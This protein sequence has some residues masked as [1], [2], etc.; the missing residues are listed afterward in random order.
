MFFTHVGRI[1]AILAVLFGALRLVIGIMI[2]NELMLPYEAALARYAPGASSSGEVID[3]GIY[4]IIFGIALGIATEISYAL[5]AKCSG[6][7][8]T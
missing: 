1:V 4:M 7:Q 6:S 3:K 8:P 2:A 5:R